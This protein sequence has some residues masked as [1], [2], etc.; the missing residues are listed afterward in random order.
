MKVA[1]TV[2]LTLPFSWNGFLISYFPYISSVV[3]S[4]VSPS[5]V[6][7]PVND[8]SLSGTNMMSPAVIPVKYSFNTPLTALE[9]QSIL[10]ALSLR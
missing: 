9:S 5:N 4:F 1:S 10:P 8:T 6:T 3:S 7:L 2:T